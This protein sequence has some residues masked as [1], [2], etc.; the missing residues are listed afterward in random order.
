MQSLVFGV[1]FQLVFE[2][3]FARDFAGFVPLLTG[4]VV[5]DVVRLRLTGY[6]T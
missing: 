5:G 2:L 1:G 6:Q 4:V 3:V